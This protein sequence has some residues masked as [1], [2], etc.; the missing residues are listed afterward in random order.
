[1]SE[2]FVSKIR[3]GRNAGRNPLYPPLSGGQVRTPRC[4]SHLGVYA[5]KTEPTGPGSATVIISKIDTYGS[6]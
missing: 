1:M 3:F 5:A 6:V 2:K 4:T